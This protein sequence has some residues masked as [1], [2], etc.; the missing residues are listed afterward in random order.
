MEFRDIN[1]RIPRLVYAHP[2]S[3][4]MSFRVRQLSM[5]ATPLEAPDVVVRNMEG[6]VRITDD[7][8]TL[9]GVDLRLPESRIKGA[10]TYHV[11]A[12]DVDLDLKSDTLTFADIRAVTLP[13]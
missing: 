6:D 11:S 2:D 13:R 3:T 10:L 1:A 7:T 5:L 9:R 12:G 4:A 8:V